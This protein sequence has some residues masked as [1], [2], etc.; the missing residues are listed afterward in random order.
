MAATNL[1][2]DLEAYTCH[3]NPAFLLSSTLAIIIVVLS[4]LCLVFLSLLLYLESSFLYGTPVQNDVA[5]S[6][7]DSTGMPA[8]LNPMVINEAMLS[9]IL[10]FGAQATRQLQTSHLSMLSL[11]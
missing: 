8:G 7:F 3:Q 11:T 9:E 10:G 2:F 4:Y 1:L 6:P 5:A